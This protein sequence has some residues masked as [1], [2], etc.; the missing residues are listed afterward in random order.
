MPAEAAAAPQAADPQIVTAAVV[1]IGNEILSGRTED[2]NLHYIAAK[3]TAIGVRLIEARVVGDTEQAIVAAL[4]ACRTKYDYVFTTGG[5]GP[6]HD[7]ITCDAV[8][9]AMG[10]RVVRHPDAERKLRAYLGDRVNEARLR[11]AN[12]PEGAELIENAV[13]VAPG[14]R[15]ENVFVLAGVPAVMRAMMDEIASRLRAGARMLSV[16][17]SAFIAEGDVA[18]GLEAIQ[19][20]Y[21]D[22]D[23]G[24]YPFFRGGKFG[25]SLVVRGIDPAR[26]EAARAEI[27]KLVLSLGGAL[28]PEPTF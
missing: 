6:T 21:P 7:D 25:T 5:I 15:I 9:K 27:E 24:S 8:A 3:L 12:V 17:V 23:I 11:M 4:D 20:R 16:A 18:A 22:F 19:K 10:R 13:S 26:V 14:F 28:A 2:K 1:I